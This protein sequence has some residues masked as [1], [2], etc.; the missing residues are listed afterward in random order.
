LLGYLSKN[1]CL[2][3]EVAF[4]EFSR[5]QLQVW[6][7]HHFQILNTLFKDVNV[8]EAIKKRYLQVNKTKEEMTKF[9]IRRCFLFI[10]TQLNY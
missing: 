3:K 5:G 1:I 9:I 7:R 4:E 10:K 8:K 6:M 2:L